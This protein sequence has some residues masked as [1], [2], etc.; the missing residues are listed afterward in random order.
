MRSVVGA[1]DRFL[2]RAESHYAQERAE[3]F[4]ACDAMRR[5]HA[6]EKARR[7]PV[8]FFRQPESWLDQL[9]AFLQPALDQVANFIQLPARIDR[10][11]VGIL[12]ERIGDAKG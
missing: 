6:G 3:N 10:A 8:T 2:W 11:D 4:L 7:I 12:V 1:L 9:R 5:S